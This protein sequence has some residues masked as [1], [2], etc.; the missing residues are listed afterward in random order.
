MK[1]IKFLC[2]ETKKE[3]TVTVVRGEWKYQC[4]ECGTCSGVLNEL[5]ETVEVED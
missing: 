4:S 2:K 5:V 1:K 3:A